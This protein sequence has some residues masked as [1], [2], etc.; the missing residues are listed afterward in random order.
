MTNISDKLRDVHFSVHFLVPKKKQ[1]STGIYTGGVKP[2]EW[3]SISRKQR[4]QALSKT[5][6]V[7]WS[8][9]NPKT[10]KLERQQNIKGG[11]NQFKDK[12]KRLEFLKTMESNLIKLLDYG[13]TPKEIIGLKTKIDNR[14]A[15]LLDYALKIK[16]K[17]VSETTYVGYKSVVEAFKEHLQKDGVVFIEDVTKRSVSTFLNKFNGKT[18]NNYKAA[19]SSIYSVL[20]D[21]SWIKYNFIKELRNK[22][23]RKKSKKTFDHKVMEDSLKK[24]EKQ[25]LTLLVY[26]EFISYMFWR[27]IETVRLKI[28]GID[29]KNMTMSADTKGKDGKTKTIPSIFLDNLKKFIGDRQGF[30]FELNATKDRDKRTYL[31]HRFKSFRDRNKL[32]PSLT[33]YVYRHYYITKLYKKLRESM[34]REQ[35]IKE[36]SL[37]TGHDSKA[38][39]NYIHVNDIELAEDYSEMLK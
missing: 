2:S 20:S 4:E 16:E 37:I 8:F 23:I 27:P 24:L 39:W 17:E 33:P 7:R 1:Y 25:D 12:S 28:E 31:T 15:N 35:A 30:V 21:E 11:A 14:A 3:N 18:S 32:D 5:W 26:I 29:L 13:Y 19:L 36:L 34:P 6:Y 38:I 10:G 22:P 9:R